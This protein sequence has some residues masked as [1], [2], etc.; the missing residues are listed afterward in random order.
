[1]DR[2]RC[3]V[4]EE[5]LSGTPFEELNRFFSQGEID[6]ILDAGSGK[7]LGNFLRARS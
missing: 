5:G 1:M 2:H 4:E 7:A 6:V 3:E